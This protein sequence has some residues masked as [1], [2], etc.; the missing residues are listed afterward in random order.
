M[1][2]E[3]KEELG[4]QGALI[5]ERED[6]HIMWKEKKTAARMSDYI[7]RVHTIYPPKKSD[8]INV[9]VQICIYCF[10]EIFSYGLTIH[11]IPKS[12][13]SS[14]KSLNIRPELSF[15]LLVWVVQVLKHDWL[16][17]NNALVAFRDGK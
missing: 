7:L 8:D 15:E 11:L 10:Y 17:I 14:N 16:F 9:S 2:G 4:K 3:L 12:H 13:R 5:K 6:N 1:T